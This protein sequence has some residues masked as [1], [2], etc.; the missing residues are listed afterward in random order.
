MCLG[1]DGTNIVLYGGSGMPS[2]A[3]LQDTW[4]FT[5]ATKTWAKASSTLTAN[6]PTGR[7]N[8]LMAS[9]CTATAGTTSP[10]ATMTYSGIVMYSG[11]S[12]QSNIA[13]LWTWTHAAGWTQTTI[14]NTTTNPAPPARTGATFVANGTGNAYLFGGKTNNQTLNDM[15]KWNGTSFSQVTLKGDVISIR[16]G[17]SMAYDFSTG[18]YILFGGANDSGIINPQTFTSSDAI[19]WTLQKPTTSPMALIGAQMSYDSATVPGNGNTG[20]VIITG[21]RSEIYSNNL[22]WAYDTIGNNWVAL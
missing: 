5:A 6:G 4:L 17:H 22:T 2:D 15:W 11:K 18:K 13:E 3:I 10:P 9:L 7:A 21:G 8:A 16:H 19:T 12:L 1:F 20:C 14:T